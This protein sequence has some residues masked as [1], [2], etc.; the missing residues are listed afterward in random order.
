MKTTIVKYCI[1]LMTC[2]YG[3]WCFASSQFVSYGILSYQYGY[4]YKN[5][6]DPRAEDQNFA[7]NRLEDF[8]A[9][10]DGATSKTTILINEMLQFR[11]DNFKLQMVV[12]T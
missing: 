3:I 10:N 9:P 11:S 1:L 8:A 2:V 4:K 12:M 5:Y 6:R 7:A